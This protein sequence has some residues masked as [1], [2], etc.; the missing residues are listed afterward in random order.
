MPLEE[1]NDT[2]NHRVTY[3]A[4]NVDVCVLNIVLLT[5]MIYINP[6]QEPENTT[7]HYQGKSTT[8]SKLREANTEEVLLHVVD[9]VCLLT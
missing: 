7:S 5:N 6:M 8:M 3:R 1:S 9:F 2:S 4:I